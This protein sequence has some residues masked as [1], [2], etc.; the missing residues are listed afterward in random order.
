MGSPSHRAAG[1]MDRHAS[2]RHS[3]PT[4]RRATIWRERQLALDKEG[5]F[6][7]RCMWTASP[8]SAPTWRAAP[9]R[10]DQPVSAS[11]GHGLRHSRDC[12][13]RPAVLTNTTP[14]G[15]TRGPGFAEAVNIIERLI[16]AAARQCGFDRIDLRRRNFV[17]TACR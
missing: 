12:I 14:I 15:V 3:C 8:I 7:A 5:K 2:A 1:K 9:A 10:A 6:L 4:T 17:A 11:P 13:A 16:D